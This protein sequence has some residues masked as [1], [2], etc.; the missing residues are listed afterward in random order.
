MVSLTTACAILS[1]K[2]FQIT[3][4]K[5]YMQSIIFSGI[6]FFWSIIFLSIIA[7]AKYFQIIAG[8]NS[9]VH[10]NICTPFFKE[11]FCLE[12]FMISFWHV[13]LFLLQVNSDPGYVLFSAIGT[14]F[15]PMWEYSCICPFIF[16]SYLFALM[17][18]YSCI[19]TPFKSLMTPFP[20]STI[21]LSFLHFLFLLYQLYISV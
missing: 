8:H 12:F 2:Y 7:S 9:P 20:A 6:I 17:W 4:L 10:R 16:L 18:E 19:Y 15:A 13:S 3:I 21:H 1:A 5:Y 11:V 14:F